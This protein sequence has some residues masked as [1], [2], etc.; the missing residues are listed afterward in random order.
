MF[1]GRRLYIAAL[2]GLACCYPISQD[3]S[4]QT[5]ATQDRAKPQQEATPP[6]FNSIENSLTRIART[7]ESAQADPA[8]N[9]EEKRS[10][11]DL[12]AQ[13]D[14]AK[15]AMWMFF[16]AVATTMLT[17]VGVFLIWRTLLHTRNAAQA[18]ERMAFDTTVA[19][20]AAV[21]ANNEMREANEIA[22]DTARRQLRAYVGI[23]DFMVT[24]L[25]VGGRPFFRAKYENRGQ[26]PALD[27]I[28][29]GFLKL[30]DQRPDKV[31]FDSMAF[32]MTSSMLLMP[33]SDGW[34]ELGFNAPLTG[35]DV[36]RLVAG[37]RTF[38]F[39]GYIVYWDVFGA[40]RIT[41]FR[42]YLLTNTIQANGTA[43]V[44]AVSR[45]NLAS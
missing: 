39:A 5:R 40:R 34:S 24:G 9:R 20:Q 16:A 28:C 10:E 35:P 3:A 32:D 17:A 21:E 33:A 2:A 4:A 12:Q 13:R 37:R 29:R 6:A 42:H 44:A 31:K 26:T 27:L 15:W 11:A 19:V 8:A 18:T 30:T 25:M 43:K 14:M 7:M 36:A 41:M 45:G 22:R 38:V 23:T 1:R